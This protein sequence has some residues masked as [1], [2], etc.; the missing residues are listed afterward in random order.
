[1]TGPC[2]CCMTL[3]EARPCQDRLLCDSLLC[4]QTC[5]GCLRCRM[6]MCP[7]RY[8]RPWT[9]TSLQL[10]RLRCA[11]SEYW[12]TRSCRG[13]YC[14]SPRT[15]KSAGCL[16]LLLACIQGERN[17]FDTSSLQFILSVAKAMFICLQVYNISTSHL[18]WLQR[19][20][21]G[22]VMLHADGHG[23]ATMFAV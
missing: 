1:M 10:W 5:C 17:E 19:Y 21:S 4:M 7:S 20:S 6:C 18:C 22:H 23:Q 3:A 9:W 13:E 12:A 11:S 8:C 2:R 14:R 15:T 16:A